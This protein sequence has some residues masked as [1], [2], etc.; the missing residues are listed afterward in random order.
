MSAVPFPADPWK[1]PLPTV[2]PSQ[3]FPSPG[4][5]QQRQ[6]CDAPLQSSTSPLTLSGRFGFFLS[7]QGRYLILLQHLLPSPTQ[8]GNWAL[9]C[10]GWSL[11]SR[12]HRWLP[13]VPLCGITSPLGFQLMASLAEKLL[14]WQAASFLGCLEVFLGSF[15]H[16]LGTAAPRAAALWLHGCLEELP[17]QQ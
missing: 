15:P 16:S 3:P 17:P 9:G 13:Q 12:S 11:L 6:L 5:L 1:S 8:F 2:P 14:W 10:L 7:S 4:A